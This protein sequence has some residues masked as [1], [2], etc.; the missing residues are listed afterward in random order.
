MPKKTNDAND[1][2]TREIS[3]EEIARR[4][5]EISLE[6]GG[7]DEENWLRAEQELR[8]ESPPQRQA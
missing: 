5:F 6:S 7:T 1:L 3:H 4:A 8:R 2:P